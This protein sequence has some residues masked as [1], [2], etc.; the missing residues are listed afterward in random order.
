MQF[1]YH[2]EGEDWKGEVEGSGYFSAKI[3]QVDQLLNRKGWKDG[4]C[5]GAGYSRS[6]YFESCLGVS[7]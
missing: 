6:F 5:A 7:L 1:I 3:E 4:S 2:K